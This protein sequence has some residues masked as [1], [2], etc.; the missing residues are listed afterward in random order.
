[1]KFYHFGNRYYPLKPS[2]VG[3]WSLGRTFIVPF[4]VL[5]LHSTEFHNCPTREG[6]V[7]QVDRV[8]FSFTTH[9]RR[10]GDSGEKWSF[11]F[12][13]SQ[14]LWRWWCGLRVIPPQICRFISAL[15]DRRVL[16][17][18]NVPKRQVLVLLLHWGSN[19]KVEVFAK[20]KWGMAQ[21]A[22]F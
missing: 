22:S 11:S 2:A 7:G 5:N 9:R 6:Q 15:H 17:F 12:A 21:K 16:R 4:A 3:W 8:P 20:G 14:M 13:H 18:G 1:M 10:L 19:K